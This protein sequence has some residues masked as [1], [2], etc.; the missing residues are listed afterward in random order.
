MKH[1]IKMSKIGNR[2]QNQFFK[3][4]NF[5]KTLSE[6]DATFIN[7]LFRK[8]KSILRGPSPLLCD[9]VFISRQSRKS[10]ECWVQPLS[11]NSYFLYVSNICMCLH[12]L[13]WRKMDNKNTMHLFQETK[14]LVKK[15]SDW[16]RRMSDLT[17]QFKE[18]AALFVCV[19]YYWLYFTFSALSAIS[20]L[21]NLMGVPFYVRKW[22][23][24]PLQQ[25][26]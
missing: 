11:H 17:C 25:V 7:W 3:P 21:T 26:G 13:M 19:C 24:D 5:W 2:Q 18:S 6:S 16:G 15:I 4:A 22:W 9:C 20:L 23:V 10:N 14:L 1:W 8:P 12:R